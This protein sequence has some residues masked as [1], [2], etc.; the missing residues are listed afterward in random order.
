MTLKRSTA[1][2][3]KPVASATPEILTKQLLM[4]ARNIQVE[5]RQTLLVSGKDALYSSVK[6][7]LDGVPFHLEIVVVPYQNCVF[8]F[9][10]LNQKE[11]PEG[12]KR[13]FFSFVNSL[14]YGTN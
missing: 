4:G 12:E 10:L 6:A 9:T 13:Q 2:Y 7:T 14:Q 11:I 5:K 3:P 8:D 1:R